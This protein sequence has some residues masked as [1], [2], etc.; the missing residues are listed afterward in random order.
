MFNSDNL[1][2][3]VFLVTGGMNWDIN[4]YDAP[5]D[6]TEVY[7]PSVGSWTAGAR[8]PSPM[9]VLKAASIEDQ[10]LNFGKDIF[11]RIQR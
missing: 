7:D 8:L 4:W 1:H 3:Q 5:L 6:T 10:I 11:F 2:I 9:S